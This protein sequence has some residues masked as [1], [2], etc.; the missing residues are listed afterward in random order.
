MTIIS[1]KKRVNN[2]I[3]CEKANSYAKDND[4]D[5][6]D[7]ITSIYY[8][9]TNC[10][11]NKL[12][13]KVLLDERSGNIKSIE[14]IIDIAIKLGV[15]G[16]TLI[17]NVISPTD[18][19]FKKTSSRKILL[20]D[21]V[22]EKPFL[23]SINLIDVSTIAIINESG[24]KNILKSDSYFYKNSIKLLG[25]ENTY[26][27]Y[28]AFIDKKVRYKN[29]SKKEKYIDSILVTVKVNQLIDNI[30]DYKILL[31]I[32]NELKYKYSINAS[33]NNFIVE[34]KGCKLYNVLKLN[35]DFLQFK[36]NIKKLKIEKITSLD[37]S[38]NKKKYK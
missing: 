31:N 37:V 35:K 4:F 15:I 32:K 33:F 7:I 6:S 13:M 11:I 3:T 8:D 26:M 23:D 18:V 16:D 21:Y 12:G 5:N 38:L 30:T 17:N 19:K 27:H 9:K 25:I 34:N 24:K 2:V 20:I 28:N 29:L 14:E 22:F 10:K 1:C 36:L